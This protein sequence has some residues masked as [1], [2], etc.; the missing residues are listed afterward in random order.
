[1]NKLKTINYSYYL[2]LILVAVILFLCMFG[3]FMTPHSL[4]VTLETQYRDGKVLAPPLEP[5]ENT[6]FLFGTDRWGYDLLSMILFGIRYTVFIALAVTVIKMLAGTLIGLYAGT[7]KKTPT[8]ITA[9]EKAWSYIPLFLILYF[10]L[11]PI[12]VNS[13]LES[14]TLVVYFILVA[15]IISIPSVASSVRLKTMEVHKSTYIEAARTLGAKK[16]RL[17]WKHIFPQLKESLLVMFILEVVYVI[18]IMGQLALMNIFVGGTIMRFDPTIYLSVTK[19]LAGLV[20]Q[21][22]G[23]IYGNTHILYVPLAVLLFT[24][25]S[26]SLLANGLKN[27]FQSDYQRT[28]WIKTGQDPRVRPARKQYG[29]QSWKSVTVNKIIFSILLLF[30]AGAGAYVYLT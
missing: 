10:F 20:G 5:F 29:S 26:F 23:N 12:T 27:K 2:G 15:A 30:F 17:I 3:P 24:T 13:V 25:I 28:P 8:I 16:N 19:E 22:Q 1:M 18:T 7:M 6:D 9:F 4:T 11:M 14:S 21:A